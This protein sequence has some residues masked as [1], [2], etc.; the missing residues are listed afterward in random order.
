LSELK[1]DFAERLPTSPDS[2]LIVVDGSPSNGNVSLV[3]GSLVGIIDH[4]CRDSNPTAPFID[5][6]PG[7]ASCSTLIYRFW[8]EAGETIPM[9]L[10]TA[11]L[12]G[13]QSDTDFMSRRASAEDFAAYTELFKLGD[14]ELASRI[15]RTVLDLRELTLVVRALESAVNHDGLLFAW[16]P[17]PC[18]QEV[19]AVLAEFVLRTEELR[20]VIIAEFG[21]DE[22]GEGDEGGGV[23]LSVRSK[24]PNLSAFSLIKHALEGIGACGGHSHSAGG[25]V[26]N[27]TF[28]GPNALRERFFSTLATS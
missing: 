9:D 15:V 25:F 24:D 12:T 2:Q 3:E 14:F 18:G 23:H 8:N 16:L 6:E 26:P 22:A 5:I 4:H 1:L 28:P 7:L 19:L 27:S 17:G 13:I 20:V 11:L 10:A 21:E